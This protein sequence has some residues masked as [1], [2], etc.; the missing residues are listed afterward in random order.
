MR[1]RRTPLRFPGMT[2]RMAEAGAVSAEQRTEGRA[3]RRKP[4]ASAYYLVFILSGFSGLIYESIWSRY[5]KLFLG[6]DAHAQTL[7]LAIFL[8]GLAI[9]SALAS[10]YVER[11]RNPLLVY[12]VVEAVV[13]VAGVYFHDIFIAS[14]EWVYASVLPVVGEGFGSLL[15][16]WGL[17]ALLIL[18]Q[19]VLLGTT[20]PLMS[21]GV[22]RICPGE[23]GR[24]IAWLY[25]SNSVGASVGVLVSG[26]FLVEVVGLPGTV[27]IAG[28]LSALAGAIVWI[29]HHRFD[30]QG[31]V[32]AAAAERTSRVP[33]IVLAVAA[34]TGMASFIYE[35]A[36]IR[37][38]TL[39]IGSTAHAFELML[40]AF[41]LGLAIGG[42]WI[43]RRLDGLASPMGAL[44]L[45]QL[46]M[47]AFAICTLFFYEG[48][49]EAM[50]IFN[51][52]VPRTEGYYTLYRTF[53]YAAAMLLMLPA[54]ICA[55]MTLPLMTNYLFTSGEGE[56][57]VG[58]VYA[59]NTLGAIVG[60][61][62]AVYVLMPTI[63]LKN[64]VVAGGALDLLLGIW[65]AFRFARVLAARLCGMGLAALAAGTAWGGFPPAIYVGSARPDL[66]IPYH[67]EGLT[68]SVAVLQESSGKA[69]F[70]NGLSQSSISVPLPA[71]N[72]E[73][74]ATGATGDNIVNILTA[75]L[76][77]MFRPDAE[78]VANVGFGSGLTSETLLH[79]SR[80]GRLDTIEIESEVA[81][82]AEHLR[83]SVSRALDDPRHRI[84]IND[85]RAFF[86]ASS[87][88]RYD[89]IISE[90]PQIWRKGIPNLFTQN[91][92]RMVSEN[93]KEGGIFT[94][95]I[96][97]YGIDAGMVSSVFK[98]LAEELGDFMVFHAG[99]TNL[100][101]VASKQGEALPELSG[102]ILEDEQMRRFV[103]PWI[104]HEDDVRSL[105]IG[106]R[107]TLN[108]LFTGLP[109]PPNSDYFPYL[110]SVSGKAYFLRRRF[111]LQ[112]LQGLMGFAFIDML[113]GSPF[114]A[115]TRKLTSNTSK[116]P[117][118]RA[119]AAQKIL[120]TDA[121]VKGLDLGKY[122]RNIDDAFLIDG[123]HRECPTDREE[124]LLW[125]GGIRT[126]T[127][128]THP[129]AIPKE[130]ETYWRHNLD[131][132]L[133]RAPEEMLTTVLFFRA[134]ALWD[135]R[136]VADMADKIVF[137][138][139]PTRTETMMI[140]AAAVANY[141][142][143]RQDVSL[144]FLQKLPSDLPETSRIAVLIVEGN[145]V[146]P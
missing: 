119:V 79:S 22:I 64:T 8:L 1:G 89:V 66:D 15:A 129:Y 58:R 13:A 94:Q 7:V 5:L 118:K 28:M 103:L 60:V 27:L 31:S 80:L 49:F 33:E 42:F 93:L 86:A 71:N 84:W 30:D 37:M 73:V 110:E 50:K 65:I 98:A 19:T 10:R 76:P 108:P 124:W 4:P 131:R 96:Q 17:A 21:V 75:L 102:R 57:A 105:Y 20:F 24:T 128:L 115:T 112:N 135:F 40:S 54:T 99:G 69:I 44:A 12:A 126:L 55:G 41:I 95:W 141:R 59:A 113:E 77:L 39:V 97:L 142:I 81:R 38:L 46:L 146:G 125:I 68:A 9:G 138:D 114:R 117:N 72:E 2:R 139:N 111:P 127:A 35:I 67:R 123:L 78:N 32:R 62:A 101:V 18:P 88:N 23:S 106:S 74:V 130:S 63:G 116:G 91:Y 61:A 56:R 48:L 70:V 36:W 11:I 85:A 29:L 52:G 87:G 83:P 137:T 134:L 145:L 120:D 6:H 140:I 14:T 92:Y 53:Q 100:L 143:G 26:F 144:L 43:R 122:V 90:P 45:V 133:S 82:A 34:L 132:C 51:R 136:Q 25:F 109:A 107:K 16:R 121:P 3:I 104:E 47:G